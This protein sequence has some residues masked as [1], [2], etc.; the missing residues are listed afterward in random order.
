MLIE[1]YGF[2]KCQDNASYFLNY[3]LENKDNEKM[4]SRYAYTHCLMYLLKI[5]E[6]AQIFVNKAGFL[7]LKSILEKDCLSN[8]QIAYNVCCT[9]WILSY[10][11]FAMNGFTDFKLNIIEHVSKILDFFNKEKIVRIICMLFHNLKDN[12]L[13]LEHL[14]MINALNLVI[15]LQNRPW[16]DPEIVTILE[17]LF[18]FF[19][20]NYQ[21]FSSFEKWKAQIK[22]KSLAWSPVHTEKFWQTSFIFFN[23]A[24]NLECID[25]LVDILEWRPTASLDQQALDQMKAVAC[26][27]LGEFARFFPLGKSYLENLQANLKIGHLMGSNKS[28]PELKKE[29]I[30]AYQK[31]LMNSWGQPS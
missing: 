2:A 11:D 13:C 19:D 6:L 30:T 20:Q 24:E 21:E 5:N 26:Y 10:N 8:G 17:D 16:V 18:K 7:I 23:E 27:D 14:S 1:T 15:K 28:S 29:A 12:E 4:L 31:L 9:L 3:L 22:R 25:I